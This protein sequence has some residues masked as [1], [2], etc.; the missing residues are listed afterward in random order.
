MRSRY[1][2]FAKIQRPGAERVQAMLDFTTACR[3]YCDCVLARAKAITPWIRFV[4]HSAHLVELFCSCDDDGGATDDSERLGAVGKSSTTYRAH[5]CVDLG[6]LLLAV[7]EFYE[8]RGSYRHSIEDFAGPSV[9]TQAIP[10][11]RF[12]FF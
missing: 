12:F 9:E 4:E 10:R 2:R 3:K 11:K 7:F 5:R 8:V 6:L 1:G